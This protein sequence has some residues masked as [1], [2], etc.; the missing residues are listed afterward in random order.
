MTFKSI[1][2]DAGGSGTRVR[3]FEYKNGNINV[4]EKKELLPFGETKIIEKNGITNN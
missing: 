1:I 3:Y 2:I 4:I